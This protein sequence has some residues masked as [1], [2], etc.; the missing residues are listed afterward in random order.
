[1]T[2]LASALQLIE[3]HRY[4]EATMASVAKSAGIAKGTLYLYFPTKET[5]FLELLGDRLA[6]WFE[7]L[8]RE[9]VRAQQSSDALDVPALLARSLAKREAMCRLLS[10]L[11]STLE[12]NVDDELVRAFKLRLA[13]QMTRGSRSLGRFLPELST[14]EVLALLLRTHA[15]TVGLVQ[16]ATARPAFTGVADGDER[17]AAFRVDFEREL[18]A[19]LSLWLDGWQRRAVN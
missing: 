10:I 12:R 11:H 5:L 7:E 2:I 6:A 18:M 16:M 4:D 1:M 8:E 15:L 14:D 19:S 13:Q 17:L 3:A 9:L